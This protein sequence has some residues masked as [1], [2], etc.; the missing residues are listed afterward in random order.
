MLDGGDSGGDIYDKGDEAMLSRVIGAFE[1]RPQI[2][3]T[4]MCSMI[5]CIVDHGG[6]HSSR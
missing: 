5:F 2:Q 4:M 6:Q 1:K 3:S